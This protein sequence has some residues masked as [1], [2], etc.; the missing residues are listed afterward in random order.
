ML[1]D[2]RSTRWLK[3]GVRE[4]YRFRYRPDRRWLP[5]RGG[6]DMVSIHRPLTLQRADVDLDR[7]FKANDNLI[8]M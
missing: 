8:E 3:V 1:T 5:G 7:N 2:G 4:N 6:R